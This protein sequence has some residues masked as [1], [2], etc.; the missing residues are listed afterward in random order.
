[1]N[2]VKHSKGFSIIELMVAMLIGILLLGGLIQIFILSRTNYRVQQSLN[3]MQENLRF[4]A[5]EVGYSVRMA[6]F[7]HTVPS[8]NVIPANAGGPIGSVLNS[9][10]AYKKDEIVLMPASP[11][12]IP[13]GIS[14]WAVGLQGF[15]GAPA[16]PT[17]CLTASDYMP[18]TDVFA[19]TFLRPVFMGLPASPAIEPNQMYALLIDLTKREIGTEQAGI[20][21]PGNL[22]PAGYINRFLYFDP[23]DTRDID[24]IAQNGTAPGNLIKRSAAM[25]PLALEL[26]YIRRCSVQAAGNCSATSD[27]GSPQPTLVRRRLLSDGSLVDEAVVDGIEQMQVEYLASGCGG[28]TNAVGVTNWTA[29][30]GT[31]PQAHRRWQRVIGAR[32]RLL[33]R[34]ATRDPG[35]ADIG[36]YVL[37]ADTPAY[38]PATVATLAGNASFRHSLMTINAQPRNAVRPLPSLND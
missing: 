36:P 15:N 31:V 37:S 14:N 13:C 29:C 24:F 16:D 2:P 1:M 20:I 19:V 21:G 18:N 38:N 30:A 8:P 12:V 3:Y 23:A 34:A 11:A 25:M 6:G 17:G 28:Y 10:N 26:Y 5:S 4:A 7:F 32:I 35:L 22:I 9:G 33:A 27:G